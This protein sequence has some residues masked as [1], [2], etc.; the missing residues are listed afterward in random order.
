MGA[1]NSKS[2][3]Y[4]LNTITKNISIDKSEYET[5]PKTIKKIVDE[6]YDNNFLDLKL[7]TIGT[8]IDELL[9]QTLI[10]YKLSIKK[11]KKTNLPPPDEQ[12]M[13]RP[14]KEGF[15]PLFKQITGEP[16]KPITQKGG[17]IIKKTKKRIKK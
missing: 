12:K 1:S 7:G 2:D 17:K 8:K 14:Y 15:I 16:Y 11:I 13:M 5:T 6:L 10:L 3:D 4:L 9:L